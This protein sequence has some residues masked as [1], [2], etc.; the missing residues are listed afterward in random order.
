MLGLEAK[1][2]RVRTKH[3]RNKLSIL[4]LD[5]SLLRI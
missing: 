4:R 5:L 2:T 3:A 1:Y